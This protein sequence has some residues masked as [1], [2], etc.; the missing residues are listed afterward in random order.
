MHA[1]VYRHGSLYYDIRNNIRRAPTEVSLHI[2]N[3]EG[4]NIEAFENSRAK[5]SE[6]LTPR[7]NSHHSIIK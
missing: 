6:K 4:N 7:F 3:D 5:T 2:A 1:L